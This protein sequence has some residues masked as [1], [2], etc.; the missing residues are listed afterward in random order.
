M[1]F[2]SHLCFQKDL[3]AVYWKALKKYQNNNA[4]MYLSDSSYGKDPLIVY[5]S[6]NAQTHSAESPGN[7]KGQ[8]TT[9]GIDCA[10]VLLSLHPTLY[11]T[12]LIKSLE[13]TLRFPAP[14]R[15]VLLQAPSGLCVSATRSHGFSSLFLSTISS[16]LPAS[17]SSMEIS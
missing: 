3:P 4:G 1:L 11:P 10:A 5:I 13:I 14:S 7:S 6:S 17:S 12:A 2:R 16:I 8:L 9:P 15:Y